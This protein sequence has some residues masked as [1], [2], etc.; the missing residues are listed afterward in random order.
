MGRHLPTRAERHAAM[1]VT[2]QVITHKLM[3]LSIT[4]QERTLKHVVQRMKQRKLGTEEEEQLAL[5]KDRLSL[6]FA[7]K[8][9]ASVSM[10]LRADDAESRD[11][12][13]DALI[14]DSQRALGMAPKNGNGR[15]LTITA[16]PAKRDE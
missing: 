16:E 1:T 9:A 4:A 13:L 11:E 7:P 14:A 15:E 2:T 8:F 12:Q 3:A 6:A 10:K 5:I